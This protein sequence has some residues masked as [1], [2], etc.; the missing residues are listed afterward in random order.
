MI[1]NNIITNLENKILQQSFYWETKKN[2]KES[3]ETL[4]PFVINISNQGIKIRNEDIGGKQQDFSL[5]LQQN[6]QII[7]YLSSKI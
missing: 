3:P 2:H 7:P 1:W 6:P 4:K 5:F